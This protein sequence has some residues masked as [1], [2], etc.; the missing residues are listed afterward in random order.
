MNR[1]ITESLVVKPTSFV[2]P[3]EVSLVFLG[4]PEVERANFEVGEELAVVVFVV[5]V[6]VEK[7]VEVSF[8]VDEMRVG[9][10]ESARSWPK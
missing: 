10:G 2:E 3:V 5:V 6:G 7:P 8:G 4:A 9:V 1:C